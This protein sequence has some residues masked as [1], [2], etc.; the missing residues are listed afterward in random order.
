[1]D[2]LNRLNNAF[3]VVGKAIKNMLKFIKE[4]T[5]TF[6]P[7]ISK[8]LAIAANKVRP[9]IK[10][11]IGLIKVY[12]SG[13]KLEPSTLLVATRSF[14]LGT[15]QMY[16]ICNRASQMDELS[17]SIF[18]CQNV[19]KL[20]SETL[21]DKNQS[22]SSVLLNNLQNCVLKFTSL[23]RS[24][25]PD[26]LDS[27]LQDQISTIV[28]N[29]EQY[30]GEIF[31]EARDMLDASELQLTPDIQTALT[32]LSLSL[33]T[34]LTLRP[35]IDEAVAADID[36]SRMIDTLIEQ[37]ESVL[38]NHQEIQTP[39][40]KQLLKYLQDLIPEMKAI[41]TLNL[42]AVEEPREWLDVCGRIIVLIN[43]IKETVDAVVPNVLDESLTEV[44]KS[45]SA[46]TEHFLVQFKMGVCVIA[47]GVHING[48][49]SMTFIT[50]IKDF[51]F[52]TYPFVYNLQEA[53]SLL[54]EKV[55]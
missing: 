39:G 8:R 52:I 5:A 33:H 3:Q 2:E 55:V 43:G 45:Y 38:D 24:R 26:T 48:F 42:K 50:P 49:D 37:I 27:N 53:T 1:M 13:T 10:S 54:E 7:E 28:E 34:T 44:M 17:Q 47:F 25:L 31:Y 32:Q 30:I 14:L 20:L 19:I 4:Y 21:T 29:S 41:N 6:P 9:H 15:Y 18:K 35:T 36:I 16:L 40:V 22:Q 46:S 51:I 12:N 23:L 11:L